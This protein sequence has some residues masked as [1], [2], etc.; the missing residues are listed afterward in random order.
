MH[1]NP[2]MLLALVMKFCKID[3]SLSSRTTEE[4]EELLN[5]VLRLSLDDVTAAPST[6][7]LPGLVKCAIIGRTVQCRRRGRRSSDRGGTPD[8]SICVRYRPTYLPTS[9]SLR[10]WHL[11]CPS[12]ALLTSPLRRNRDQ[13]Q[14]SRVR[15]K[16]RPSSSSPA[17]TV[18][19]C[20][21]RVQEYRTHMAPRCRFRPGRIGC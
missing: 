1:D 3:A 15:V 4:Y 12:R 19:T 2:H 20:I 7:S 11:T 17:R 5:M 21:P 9:T 10:T 8:T 14:P 6:R 18:R 16:P 13:T